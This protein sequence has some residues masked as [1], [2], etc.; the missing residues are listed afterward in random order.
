MNEMSINSLTPTI[1]PWVTQSCLM[2][3]SVDRP[4]LF[5]STLLWYCL[6]FNFIQ[7]VILRNLSILYVV[8]SGVKAL[9]AIFQFK[10]ELLSEWHN[11]GRFIA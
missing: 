5:S 10:L 7:L 11:T 3:D 6:I 9:N 2:F 1:K 8:L 4:L